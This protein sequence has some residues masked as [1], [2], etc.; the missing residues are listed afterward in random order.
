MIVHRNEITV[1]G[2]GAGSNK[3]GFEVEESLKDLLWDVPKETPTVV[4]EAAS[5]LRDKI[6]AGQNSNATA[7]YQPHPNANTY[8]YVPDV[9]PIE[10]ARFAVTLASVKGP[11]KKIASLLRRIISAR[12]ICRT[13]RD[14][15]SGKL[16][17]R[18]LHKLNCPGRQISKNV[19]KRRQQGKSFKVGVTLLIDQ[20]GS[21]FEK[22]K[23]ECAR[24]SAIAL[25]EALSPLTTHGVKFEI[26]GFNTGSRAVCSAGEPYDRSVHMHLHEYKAFN[27]HWAKVKHRIEAAKT[28]G[29]NADNEAIRF[30]VKRLLRLKSVDRRVLIVMSDGK[31]SVP[32][33]RTNHKVDM[34]R[35]NK[36][37]RLAI[38]EA[39][40]F[41]VETIG[42]GVMTE[43]VRL[44]YR[45]NVVIRR[46][47]DL[48]TALMGKLKKVL[49]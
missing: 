38:R 4:G 12:S 10:R 30:A 15:E 44:F 2:E 7:P 40:A 17:N 28:A 46:V 31:P 23:I 37:V 45:N 43:D 13:F 49:L 11:S 5:Q 39:N 24:A 26:L 9:G 3:D 20:S 35:L 41:G 25:G 14:R 22:D 32:S 42:I 19:F 21:M 6:V 33:A 47:A 48:E 29:A 16:D 1:K 27:D 8:L 36:D 18:K 34:V